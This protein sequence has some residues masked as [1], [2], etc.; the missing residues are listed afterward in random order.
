MKRSK[1]ER[2]QWA[3]RWSL[4]EAVIFTAIVVLC[5]EVPFIIVLIK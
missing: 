1:K 3:K 4:F 5:F 2:E